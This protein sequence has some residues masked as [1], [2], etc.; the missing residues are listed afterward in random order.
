VI[1]GGRIVGHGTPAE[2]QDSDDP[3]VRQFILGEPDGPVK[4]HYPARTYAEDLGLR[5]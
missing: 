3:E 4:F 2:V 5:A 1:S